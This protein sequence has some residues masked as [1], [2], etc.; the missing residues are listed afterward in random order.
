MGR[1]NRLEDRVDEFQK[2]FSWKLSAD[3]SVPPKDGDELCAFSD[4]TL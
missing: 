4:L 3:W 2:V 1:R